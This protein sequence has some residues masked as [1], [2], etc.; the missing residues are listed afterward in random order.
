MKSARTS[1]TTS[2]LF[3]FPPKSISVRILPDLSTTASIATPS[4]EISER[5]VPFLGRA[6]ATINRARVSS[7][8]SFKRGRSRSRQE[9]W[10]FLRSTRLGNLTAAV[11]FLRMAAYARTGSISSNNN[12][13]GE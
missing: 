10:Q 4:V 5:T 6:S 8:A 12:A 3:S 2:S 9:R 1:F 11:R 7:L 13:H